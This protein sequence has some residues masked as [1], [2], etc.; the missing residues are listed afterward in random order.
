MHSHRAHLLRGTGFEVADESDLDEWLAAMR[1][2]SPTEGEKTGL[3]PLRFAICTG[4]LALV[5]A[6]LRTPGINTEAPLKKA[7]PE[8]GWSPN[9][10]L[11]HTAARQR[12]D[13]AMLQ[14]LMAHGASPTRKGMLGWMPIMGAVQGGHTRNFD[15]FAQHDPKTLTSC[16]CSA[17]RRSPPRAG[18]SL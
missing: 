12:D 3:C 17:T 7:Y 16:A 4:R 6:L 18:A 2:A 15:T 8:F 10:S 11:L 9:E 14:L 13:P 5:E 1:F